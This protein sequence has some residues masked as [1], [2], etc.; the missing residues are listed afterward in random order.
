LTQSIVAEESVVYFL[1][2]GARDGELGVVCDDS[3]NLQV[4]H[5]SLE[6]LSE[7]RSQAGGRDCGAVEGEVEYIIW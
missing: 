2:V 5:V 4:V 1:G 7:L 6:H 3:I